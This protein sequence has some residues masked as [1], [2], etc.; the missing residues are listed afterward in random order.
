MSYKNSESGRS[1]IEVIGVM[2][3]G[4]IMIAGTFQVYS[5]MSTRMKRMEV[6]EDMR[7]LAKNTKLLFSGR[8]SYNGVSIAYLIKAGALKTDRAP[9]IATEYNVRSENDGAE[10]SINLMGVRYN[11]CVWIAG[12]KIDFAI[13]IRTNDS[14]LG[15]AAENCRR[16]EENKVSI[17]AR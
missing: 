13:A 9:A 8:G 5:V 17:I 3:L 1:L 4:A 2:A 12:A 10:F 7:D 15:D 11:D 14:V 16:G 6:I